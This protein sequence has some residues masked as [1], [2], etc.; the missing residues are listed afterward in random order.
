MSATAYPLQWPEG[1]SRTIPGYRE[2]S[3]Y[4]FKS[5]SRMYG[6]NV[7]PVTFEVARKKLMDELDRLGAQHAVI[8]TNLP[9]RAD[10]QAR[11][12]A[13]RYRIEDPG[14]AVYFLLGKRQMVMACDRYDAPSANLRSIGLA[15]EAM[16]QLE[17]HGGG[18]M[19][20]RAFAGFA[21]LPAPK[22]CWEI[23]GLAPG[24]SATA[25]E[26]AFRQLAMEHHPDRGGSNAKMAEINEARDRALKDVAA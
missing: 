9:L 5:G 25:V 22:S 18:A 15:I 19:M 3:R 4:R 24:A 20:E 8:S 16:R 2:D 6:E 23:L 14:V 10:G 7:G 13:A 12:D 26:A 1:W 11:A 17:R 21:A